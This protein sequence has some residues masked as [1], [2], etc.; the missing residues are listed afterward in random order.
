[1]RRD[2]NVVVEQHHSSVPLQVVVEKGQLEKA[3]HSLESLAPGRERWVGVARDDVQRR[4]HALGV[5]LHQRPCDPE[6]R[7]RSDG[8]HNDG[9][10]AVARRHPVH[11]RYE[12]YEL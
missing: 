3:W 12:R 8:E 7:A 4:A 6:E 2:D 9:A 1:M 5:Q 10:R 11:R